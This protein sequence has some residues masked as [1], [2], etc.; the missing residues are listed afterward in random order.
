[1][2]P[3]FVKILNGTATSLD[4]SRSRRQTEHYLAERW[5]S[6]RQELAIL[7]ARLQEPEHAERS[8]IVMFC[9]KEK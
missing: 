8:N 5:E 9:K 1:M 2:E 3:L 6:S 7:E 4:V